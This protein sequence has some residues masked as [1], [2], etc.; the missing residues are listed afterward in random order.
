LAGKPD[1]QTLKAA[2]ACWSLEL[3]H[4]RDDLEITGSPERCQSRV[5]IECSDGRCYVL[6]SLHPGTI[7]YKASIHRCLTELRES[8][9]SGLNPCLPAASGAPIACAGEKF[10]QLS[11]YIAGVD[12]NRPA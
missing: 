5:V 2:A 11:G 12:L 10:W 3:T 7:D 4:R 6:E 9:L 8:G 1:L